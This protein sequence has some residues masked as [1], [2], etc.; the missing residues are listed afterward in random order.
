M[1]PIS[2]EPLFFRKNRG[3]RGA[4]RFSR[5]CIVRAGKNHRPG[6]RARSVTRIL[7]YRYSATPIPRYLLVAVHRSFHKKP[8]AADGALAQFCGTTA[9][10][11]L[12]R[13]IAQVSGPVHK[14]SGN[15]PTLQN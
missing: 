2:F 10:A 15:T 8:E 11:I 7:R 1:V 4:S 6:A 14:K 12:R 9:T 3:F 5:E 13:Y